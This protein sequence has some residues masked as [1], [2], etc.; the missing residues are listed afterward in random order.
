MDIKD[1]IPKN[2]HDFA[3]VEVIKNL[4][5]PGYKPI[6]KDLFIWIQDIN[7]P[8]AREIVPLL[9]AAGKDIVPIVNDILDSNDYVWQAWVLNYVL[10]KMPKTIK[11]E[12]KSQ[13]ERIAKNPNK[14]EKYEDL[15]EIAKEILLDL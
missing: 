12:F 5:Y 8:I 9:I 15:D 6:L 7:W 11:L 4:G 3:S 1:Y 13:L 10:I 14:D 2:K